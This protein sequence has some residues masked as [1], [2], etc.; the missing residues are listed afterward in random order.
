MAGGAAG[1]AAAGILIAN[2]IKRLTDGIAVAT[3]SWKA[4]EARGLVLSHEE[5]SGLAVASGKTR[6]KLAGT[7]GGVAVD[8]SI[9]SDFV[10]Y[11][12]TRIRATTKHTSVAT[13][14][15]HP[16]PGAIL[17]AIKSW[18]GQDLEIGDAQFDAAFLVAGKPAAAARALLAEP[19]REKITALAAARLAA[20]TWG[21]GAT[22]VMLHGVETDAEVIGLALDT[23]LEAAAW[24]T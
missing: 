16:S 1:G 22:V 11:A 19:L 4:L 24:P 9:V 14:G 5:T 21:G 7:I 6:P 18:L 15:V 8:V 17:S 2:N 13:I 3:E 20:F 12:H 23:V 10:H